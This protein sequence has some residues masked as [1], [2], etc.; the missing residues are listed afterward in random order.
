M[1]A[2]FRFAAAPKGILN[3]TRLASGVIAYGLNGEFGT[4][5]ALPWGD[6]P[7]EGD[8][9]R[10]VDLTSN[11][12]RAAEL[13]MIAGRKT[14]DALPKAAKIMT[15][16][17]RPISLSRGSGFDLAALGADDVVI[18]G[19]SVFIQ[20]L[21][22]L[23]FVYVTRVLHGFPEADLFLEL[24]SRPW[25][26]PDQ[27][28]WRLVDSQDKT[29]SAASP[30][31]RFE[32][33]EQV[34]PEHPRPILNPGRIP[35]PLILDSSGYVHPER[36]YL[37]LV[38]RVI[39]WGTPK[40][41]RGHATRSLVGQQ[42][43]VPL[44]DTRTGTGLVP[45]LTTKRMMKAGSK[46]SESNV[47]DELIWF[48]SGSTNT[49][50]MKT[51]I[52]AANTT[53]ETLD[54]LGLADLPAGYLGPG[55][56]YQWRR[57]G[58]AYNPDDIGGPSSEDLESG[59]AVDQITNLVQ[60]LSSD[61]YSRRLLVSAWN[62]V[63]LPKMALPPCHYAFQVLVHGRDLSLVATMRSTDLGLGLPYNILSYGLLAHAL[64]KLSGFRATELVVDMADCHVY[65]DH[66][67]KLTRQIHRVPKPWP[68]L[69]PMSPGP[70]TSTSAD[71]A[72]DLIDTVKQLE[73][74]PSTPYDCH[75][76]LI[77]KM[78]V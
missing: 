24:E 74:D 75:S 31:L 2:P 5:D 27:T 18:G 1:Q 69:G 14:M 34:Q 70:S 38:E 60:K 64:A 42:I 76:G 72:Q 47:V 3:D 59:T 46:L 36:A 49:A 35:R 12:P 23:R 8:K 78:A 39:L 21:P 71:P 22:Y 65:D 37:E 33:W 41:S 61:P 77:M 55:Y 63:D 68:R 11:S 4:G 29:A 28:G 54:G 17:R 19:K 56:P 13:N 30:A 16:R 52:W 40:V 62:A 10:F 73:L 25:D 50:D 43:R 7:L 67:G 66:I 20:S 9:R 32:T 51:K 58:A 57:M 6:I 48:L 26:K 45:I 53:R 15:R 44:I